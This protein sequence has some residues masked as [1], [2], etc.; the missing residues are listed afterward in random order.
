M[1]RKNLNR[2]VHYW[3]SRNLQVQLADIPLL[4]FGKRFGWNEDVILEQAFDDAFFVEKSKAAWDKIG[5][6]P[7]TQKCLQDSNIAHELI[8]LPDGTIDVDADPATIALITE[9]K[10]NTKAVNI[11]NEGGFNSNVL[12]QYTCRKFVRKEP[13]MKP[14]SR[15]W[16]DAL[17]SI[18]FPG[19]HCTLTNGATFTGDDYFISEERK[20]RE[21][22]IKDL[23]KT[24]EASYGVTELNAK[25]IAL[26]EEFDTKHGKDMYE[27][28]HSK[29]LPATTLRVLCQWKFQ[30]KVSGRKQ[31]LVDLWMEV[32]NNPPPNTW[33]D[34]EETLLMELCDGNI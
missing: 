6:S 26:I 5:I 22:H 11:L 29:A 23:E 33:S 10:K 12:K 17:A 31:E 28:E 8:V 34:T 4:V 27:L 13:I 24:K 7:F 30:K 18:K 14:N 3:Q 1:Y 21:S 9:E 16:Q 32:K 15:A 19:Q 20:R 25:A 2:L